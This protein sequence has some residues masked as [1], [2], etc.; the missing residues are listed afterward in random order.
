MMFLGSKKCTHW[1]VV[2]PRATFVSVDDAC[3]LV[4]MEKDT[5]QAQSC[6]SVGG[7]NLIAG[8]DY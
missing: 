8:P 2:M 5:R 6:P 4:T 7:S 3:A 1:T